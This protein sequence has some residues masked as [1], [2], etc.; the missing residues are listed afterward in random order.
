MAL[1]TKKI[2]ISSS[3]NIKT[4]IIQS[5]A[6]GSANILG[7]L[8]K[9]TECGGKK[10]E[11]EGRRKGSRKRGETRK[12]EKTGSAGRE[13]GIPEGKKRKLRMI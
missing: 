2:A 3:S 13:S 10:G 6:W 11:M 12:E 4:Y 8:H 5:C 9:L 7:G 1:P